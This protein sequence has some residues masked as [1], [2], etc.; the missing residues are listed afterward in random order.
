MTQAGGDVWFITGSST[1]FSRK[2]PRQPLGAGERAPLAASRL[3]H[4]SRCDLGVN[5]RN[6]PPAG[7]ATS[8][9]T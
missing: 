1:G 8:E 6:T 7:P 5:L 3:R 4:P 9:I 2:L